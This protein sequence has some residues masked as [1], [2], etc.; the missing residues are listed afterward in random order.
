MPR[1][2]SDPRVVLGRRLAAHREAKKL[3][4]KGLAEISG[5]DLTNV[6]KIESGEGNP[7]VATV[8]RIAGLL[9]VDLGELFA[10]V[11]PYE[12]PGDLRPVRIS[13]VPEAF[14]RRSDRITA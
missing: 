2:P 13:D 1:H 3:T 14:F 9:E 4:V 12:L 5:L 10:G 8:L 11:D 6:R 7:T